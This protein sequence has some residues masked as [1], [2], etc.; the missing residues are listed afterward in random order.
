MPTAEAEVLADADERASYELAFHVLPTVVEGEVPAVFDAIKQIVTNA[1]GEITDEE[2]PQRFDLAYEIVKYLEG[3]NRRFGS[4]Y[5]GW[6]RFTAPAEAIAAINDAVAARTDI[7]RHLLIRLTREEEATPFRFH[8]ALASQKQVTDVHESEVVPE[9]VAPAAS[10]DEADASD[11]AATDDDRG[12][13]E[14]EKTA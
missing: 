3:K 10:A 2:Q 1:S 7:L 12:V 11:D 6:V 8:E 9:K 4:A 5:F 14:E 13:D